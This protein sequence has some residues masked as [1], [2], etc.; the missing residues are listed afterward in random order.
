ML[1]ILLV[2]PDADMMKSGARRRGKRTERIDT[3]AEMKLWEGEC[4]VDMLSRSEA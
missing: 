1:N 2:S 4:D 3:I